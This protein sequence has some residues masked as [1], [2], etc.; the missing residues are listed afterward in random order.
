MHIIRD[1]KTIV[2]TAHYELQELKPKST[3]KFQ[4]TDAFIE[5]YQELKQHILTNC[6]NYNEKNELMSTI[7]ALQLEN[8]NLKNLNCIAKRS[9]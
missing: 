9:S 7:A 1:I 4:E 6:G 3:E 5:N 2:E 8:E